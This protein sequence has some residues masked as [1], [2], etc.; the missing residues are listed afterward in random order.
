MKWGGGN[1]HT[2]QIPTA[3]IKIDNMKEEKSIPLTHKYMTSDP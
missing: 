2:V 3:N 1:C